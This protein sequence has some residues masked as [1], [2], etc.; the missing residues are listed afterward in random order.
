M[1]YLA[2]LYFFGID[3]YLRPKEV[4]NPFPDLPKLSFDSEDV[5]LSY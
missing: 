5:I 1:A 4:I 2:F 3:L